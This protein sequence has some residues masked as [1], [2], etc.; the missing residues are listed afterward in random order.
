MR[1][2]F[3][4]R[5]GIPEK[6]TL[7]ERFVQLIPLRCPLAALAWAIILGTPGYRLFEYIDHSSTGFS[8]EPARLFNDFL[9]C[10][11]PF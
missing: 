11:V 2:S 7:I 1:L 5:M 10:L 4:L 3:V 9:Y 8:L 6:S